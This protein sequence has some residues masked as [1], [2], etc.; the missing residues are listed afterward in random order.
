MPRTPRR[1]RSRRGTIVK[2]RS[3]P[4]QGFSF[5]PRSSRRDAQVYDMGSDGLT[6]RRTPP[7]RRRRRTKVKTPEEDPFDFGDDAFSPVN[8]RRQGMYIG[9]KKKSKGKGKKKGKKTRQIRRKTSRQKG[10]ASGQGSKKRRHSAPAHL[11][12]SSDWERL[13]RL[14]A[15][16]QAKNK[17]KWIATK[18][19]ELE[20]MTPHA[21]FDEVA[22]GAKYDKLH[23]ARWEDISSEEFLELVKQEALLILLNEGRPLSDDEKIEM[24]IWFGTTAK[25]LDYD[26]HRLLQWIDAEILEANSTLLAWAQ[27][28]EGKRPE[29]RVVNYYD[30][31]HNQGVMPPMHKYYSGAMKPL[32]SE[33]TTRVAAYADT[34]MPLPQLKA[35]LLML[36]MNYGNWRKAVILLNEYL[37]NFMIDTEMDVNALLTDEMLQTILRTLPMNIPF[38]VWQEPCTGQI[39]KEARD[40]PMRSVMGMRTASYDSSDDELST[41]GGAQG[42][43]EG[44]P[45]EAVQA[46]ALD[47]VAAGGG[48]Q[49]GGD[50]AAARIERM[51]GASAQTAAAAADPGEWSYDGKQLKWLLI[52]YI[53]YK[54]LTEVSATHLLADSELTRALFQYSSHGMPLAAYIEEP[55]DLRLYDPNP[56][57]EIIREILDGWRELHGNPPQ[58]EEATR[59][60]AIITTACEQDKLNKL[61]RCIIELAQKDGADT[62]D[63]WLGVLSDIKKLYAL[64]EKRKI[65]N[66][67]ASMPHTLVLP[68]G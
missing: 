39:I 43:P 41:T 34:R 52:C 22:A 21:E 29:P 9:S 25:I 40:H 1:S 50:A 4:L 18:R 19:D 47:V 23:T 26:I 63:H 60:R 3:D 6:R 8:E 53:L 16:R 51:G 45:P 57:T 66:R 10:G 12:I 11:P 65:P 17:A 61:D 55:D 36:V 67:W 49:A 15:E 24:M 5:S 35:L 37:T 56:E 44:V 31:S 68:T 33:V 7:R 27:S 30:K 48:A 42:P 46:Q 58:E 13:E 59:I 62:S 64:H 14:R 32:P 20:E 28:A 2:A 54:L 38:I